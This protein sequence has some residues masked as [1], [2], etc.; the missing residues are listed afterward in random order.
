MLSFLYG[1]FDLHTQNQCFGNSTKCFICKTLFTVC[2]LLFCIA[3][4]FVKIM[5]WP[6]ENIAIEYTAIYFWYGA[7]VLW[8]N[9]LK[10]T[11][12]VKSMEQGESERERETERGRHTER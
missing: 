4:F 7:M 1:Y 5:F 12:A 2:F 9:F 6:Q 8:F 11:L 3:L 10:I